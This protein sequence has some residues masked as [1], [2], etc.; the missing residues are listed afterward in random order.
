MVYRAYAAI[1]RRAG[2]EQFGRQLATRM[3]L[4]WPAQPGDA[5]LDLACGSGAATLVLA[6]AGYRSVGVDRSAEMLAPAA[7]AAALQQLPID[8][9]QADIR[10]L[11]E[12]T[13]LRTGGFQLISCLFDSLNYLTDDA[14]LTLVCQAAARLLAP[15]GRFVFDLNTEHEYATWDE[16]DVVVHD[17]S[18]LLVCNQLSYEAEQRRARGRVIWFQREG[19]RWRRGEELHTQRPWREAEIA[20]ALTAAGLQLRECVTPLWQPPQGADTRLVYVAERA[21]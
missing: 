20:A 4:R 3:V 12:H 11:P 1:Y 15:G 21:G 14:D 9:I 16:R 8:W 19:T 6:R 7:E 2:L 18:D 13:T 5:A 17:S 10:A